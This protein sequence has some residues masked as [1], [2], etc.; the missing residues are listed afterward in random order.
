[1][2]TLPAETLI[3]VDT[4]NKDKGS[5][6]PHIKII[7]KKG[8]S[9]RYHVTMDLLEQI[10]SE[11]RRGAPIQE[12][13]NTVTVVHTADGGGMVTVQLLDSAHEKKREELKRCVNYLRSIV[14]EHIR[15]DHGK[16]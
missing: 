10:A 16:I 7:L 9:R 8:I 4:I 3:Y 14:M 11:I 15:T 5:D 13:W 1:M 12:Y 6:S 2:I